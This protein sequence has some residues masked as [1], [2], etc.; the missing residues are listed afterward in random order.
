[1]HKDIFVIILFSILLICKPIPFEAISHNQN[2]FVQEEI[3][4]LRGGAQ[5]LTSTA[6]GSNT[7]SGTSQGRTRQETGSGSGFIP[8]KTD[9][10]KT[11][12]NRRPGGI[13]GETGKNLPDPKPPEQ[14]IPKT[15]PKKSSIFAWN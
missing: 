5:D 3:L 11:D 8:P 12:T 15:E 10:T 6:D 1:M 14:K 13:R 7:G 2:K 4:T 9:R